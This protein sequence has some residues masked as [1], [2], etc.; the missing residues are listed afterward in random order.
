M[1]LFKKQILLCRY[2]TQINYNECEE[3]IKNTK[4]IFIML[5]H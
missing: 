5:P 3:A 4:H 1:M 2:T